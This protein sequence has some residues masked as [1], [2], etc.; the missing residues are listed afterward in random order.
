MQSYHLD[1]ILG[2]VAICIVALV[3]FFPKGRK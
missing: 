3:V 1:I 2:V